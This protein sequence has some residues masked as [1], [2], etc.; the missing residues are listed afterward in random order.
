MKVTTY[1]QEE[2]IEH[3]IFFKCET[4]YRDL[5]YTT[6]DSDNLPNIGEYVV[7]EYGVWEV[8]KKFFYINDSDDSNSW[9]FIVRNIKRYKQ[10]E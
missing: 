4:K 7:G 10:H 8:V 2:Y 9:K 5:G 6:L 3:G 1:W